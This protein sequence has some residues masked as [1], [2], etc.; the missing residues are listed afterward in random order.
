M[1]QRP[2][3][4][5]P[6]T[7]S[8]KEIDQLKE[9]ARSTTAGIWRIKRAK[10]LLGVLEGISA[11]RLMYH[12]RVPV[13]SIVKCIR[14]FTRNRMAYF[15]QP[16]RPPTAR[17]A[18]VETM[19][20]FLDN[21]P[22][23]S[24]DRWDT[25][26][27]RYIGTQFTARHIRMIRDMIAAEPDASRASIAKQMCTRLR[28]YG[29]NGKPRLATAKDILRRMA[30]DNII[31][32]SPKGSATYS[33]TKT[34]AKL[35][36]PPPG[37]PKI[38]SHEIISLIFVLVEKPEHSVIWSA[39]IHHYHYIPGHRL[40]GPQLRYLAYAEHSQSAG[41]RAFKGS[42]LAALSFSSCAWRVSCRDSYI[43]WNDEQ[44]V[45]NLPLVIN[46]SRFLILPWIKIP[47]LASRILGA[48]ARQAPQDWEARYGRKPMLLETF[49][50]QDRFRGT[51]YKAANWI[52]IGATVGYSLHGNAE[53][54]RQA[55][56]AVFLQP[57]HKRFREV[58]C[59]SPSK[60]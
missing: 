22:P 15:D 23:F 50:E 10:A 52:E 42:P 60:C 1:T 47:N 57:L 44:R 17:E 33:R 19:L 24:S 56:K 30:M 16:D 14:A 21:P 48:I 49:V 28:L 29:A 39:M 51:C 36:V 27:L 18:A 4:R 11:E 58:L 41:T 55:T 40:F 35:I 12:V 3:R 2:D 25:L 32:L 13:T 31:F 54:R 26:S 9:M 53:R 20:A 5:M 38:A 45:A 7:C 6:L 43:G 8:S 37:I 59:Q 34:P 46:N